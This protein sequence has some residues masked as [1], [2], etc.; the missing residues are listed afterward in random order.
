MNRALLLITLKAVWGCSN[1]SAPVDASSDAVAADAGDAGDAEASAAC[2][3]GLPSTSTTGVVCGT[4]T[5]NN[6]QVCCISN[7]Q[8]ASSCGNLDLAW[9]CDRSAHCGASNTCCY[10]GFVPDYSTCPAQVEAT[11]PVCQ[12]STGTCTT[13]LCQTDL[14]CMSGQTCYAVTIQVAQDTGR[15]FGIC[16]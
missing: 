13:V 14:D 11:A 4:A 9:A 10:G 16:R 7:E 15:T 1:S 8:C 3:T 12:S 6:S 5:C 2:K